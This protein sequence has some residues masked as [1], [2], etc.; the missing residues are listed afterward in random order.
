MQT[1]A[2]YR[3]VVDLCLLLF[4]ARLMGGLVSRFKMP[5]V[6]GEL[7]AGIILGPF[8]LGGIIV[9]GRPLIEFNELIHIFA[10]MGAVMVLFVAGLEMSFAEFRAAGL[11]SAVVGMAGVVIPFLMGYGV[12]T[13]LGYGPE[14]S[15]L[16][17]GFLTATSIAITVL[18]LGEMNK[19][20]TTEARIIINAA[21]IDDVLA[22]A[23]LT[24]IVSIITGGHTL[25]LLEALQIIINALVLWFILLVT[26]IFL[27]PRLI[28]RTGMWK[29]KGIVESA[30]VLTC[31]GTAALSASI[32]LSPLVGAFAAGMAVAGSNV[33]QRVK[34]F[35]DRIGL[36][37][38]PMFFVVIGSAVDPRAFLTGDFAFF[39]TI[40]GV[41]IVSKLIGCGLPAL[42]FLKDRTKA[43][44][45]GLGMIS[46]GEMGLIIAGVGLTTG[47][48]TS[49][50][51]A[52]MVAAIA[53]T[54]ILPPILLRRSYSK[55][56]LKE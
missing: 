7:L 41:A 20:K 9:N 33:I 35:I 15:L 4:A 56:N 30:A 45:V 54:S 50:I 11:P 42:Y 8:A 3:A 25:S 6:L 39:L 24:V 13:L 28:D 18:T 16:I 22:L 48:L 46:R 52:A 37:F 53:V 1:D 31:F 23:V 43:I 38:I 40:I 55:N 26:G 36:I 49:D 10:E 12:F 5:E 19:L 34:E 29:A 27:I 47:I 44:R 21:V 2:I 17:G 51:Y 14:V 32:G